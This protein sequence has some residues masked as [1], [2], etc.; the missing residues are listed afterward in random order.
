MVQGLKRRVELLITVV[1]WFLVAQ[2]ELLIK[3]VKSINVNSNVLEAYLFHTD[4][5]AVL[6]VKTLSFYVLVVDIVPK[7]MIKVY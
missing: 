5:A 1:C 6:F 2:T 3:L 7:N 4:L